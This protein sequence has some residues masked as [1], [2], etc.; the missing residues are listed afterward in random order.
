MIV[1][2]HRKQH[3]GKRRNVEGVMA[4]RKKKVSRERVMEE[5]V[6]IGFAKVT[7]FLCVQNDELVIKSTDT[8]T[9]EAGAAIASIERTSQGLKVKFYDKLKALELLGKHMGM[10]DGKGY[11]EITQNNLLEEILKATQGEMDLHDIS[12]LQ[13][14]AASGN[15]LVEPS[16]FKDL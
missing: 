8:L 13:Q 1:W 16:K 2:H 3:P 15:D 4:R 9:P 6:A 10:F 7:D 5:L 14:A 12:E 11:Q